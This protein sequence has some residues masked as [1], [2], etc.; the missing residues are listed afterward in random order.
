MGWGILAAIDYKREL[1]LGTSQSP[2]PT[3]NGD[4]L[5]KKLAPKFKYRDATKIIIKYVTNEDGTV[6]EIREEVPIKLVEEVETYEGVYKLYYEKVEIKKGN[7]KIITYA[8]SRTDY[9][10]DYSRLIKVMQEEGLPAD[11]EMAY[12]TIKFA[13]ALEYGAPYLSWLAESEEEM[14]LSGAIGWQ[15]STGYFVPTEYVK[16][17]EEAA[18]KTGVDIEL[19]KAVAAVE[20]GFNPSAVSPAGAMG[21]MQLMPQTAKE[22]GVDDPFNPRENILGGAKYLKKLLDM[23]GDVELAIAAY[24]AGPGNVQKYGG[25]PPFE[26]TQNYVKKVME[27]WKQGI[28]AFDAEF[29]WPVRGEISSP[30]GERI[31]PIKGNKSM[32]TGIDIAAPLGTPII[33]AKSGTVQFAGLA[34]GYGL[35]VIIDHGYGVSTVYA[36]CFQLNVKKGQEVKQGE[37]IALVGSTG[38]ST[39]PHLHFE[40]RMNGKP[41]NPENYLP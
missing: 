19:L 31:H 11:E 12:L 22:M 1:L 6:D 3:F 16:Y 2:V 26:E 14:W 9:K 40:I 33:A 28:P 39:G 41:V 29:I 18:E 35:T 23:F 34:G 24:N 5:A 30:Y 8:L 7:T 4:K 32:H 38:L 36:H 21:I 17:F 27:L 25:I 20:S 15:W 10:K 37:I 13:E